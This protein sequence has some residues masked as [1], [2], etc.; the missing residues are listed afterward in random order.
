MMQIKRLTR[1]WIDESQESPRNLSFL[2]KGPP[3]DRRV[4]QEIQRGWLAIEGIGLSIAAGVR[5][6]Q[7]TGLSIGVYGL[8][9]GGDLAAERSSVFFYAF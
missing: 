3:I 4:L 1:G 5:Q 9:I 2:T 6:I 7:K 8:S